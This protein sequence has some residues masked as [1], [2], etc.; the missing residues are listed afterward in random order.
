MLSVLVFTSSAQSIHNAFLLNDYPDTKSNKKVEILIESGDTGTKIAEKLYSLG[1]SRQLK[2]STN[3][4]LMRNDLIRYHQVFT[5]SILKSL[6][7]L[8]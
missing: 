2:F 8:P 4:Q 5:R 1:L 6:Q 7:K 3:W